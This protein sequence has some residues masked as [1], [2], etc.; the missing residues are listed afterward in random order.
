[1]F[2]VQKGNSNPK[3]QGFL[4]LSLILVCGGASASAQVSIATASVS[5]T[6]YYVGYYGNAN[7]PGY[8]S[9]QLNVVN[10]GSTGTGLCANVYVFTSQ[11]EMVECC[12]CYL[13]PDAQIQLSVNMDLTANPL[14]NAAKVPAPTAGSIELVSSNTSGGA[15]YGV[16]GTAY[17]ATGSLRAW[18]TH[19]RETLVGAT[20]L[21][22][23][24]ETKL[25]QAVLDA[26]GTELSKLQNACY[27]IQSNGSGAGVCTCGAPPFLIN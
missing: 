20:P 19:V 2:V 12:S 5:D 17:A 4:A 24:T 15:C 6:S 1:M 16:A 13:S 23:L 14:V 27:F 11:Q 22:T 21:F 25:P 26:G 7:Y 8:P 9:A 10:P 3:I 18:N